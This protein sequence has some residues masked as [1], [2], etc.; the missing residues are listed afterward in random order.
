MDCLLVHLIL[1]FLF[2]EFSDMTK[3]WQ[4]FLIIILY[5]E[6]CRF[7]DGYLHYRNTQKMKLKIE[8]HGGR[9]TVCRP[10]KK[11]RLKPEVILLKRAFKS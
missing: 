1:Q 6:F 7:P 4:K 3:K 11:I 2:E 10:P 8:T 5:D 9:I